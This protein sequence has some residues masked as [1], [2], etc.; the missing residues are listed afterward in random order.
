MQARFVQSL[1]LGRVSPELQGLLDSVMVVR[2]RKSSTAPENTQHNTT[3]N[4]TRR[5]DPSRQVPDPSRLDPLC[6]N[7]PRLIPPRPET[8]RLDTTLNPTTQLHTM[9]TR[10]DTT[11]PLPTTTPKHTP[12][13][14]FLPEKEAQKSTFK[15]HTN[16]VNK[17]T[18]KSRAANYKLWDKKLQE[19]VRD[20][21]ATEHEVPELEYSD[22]DVPDEN[23]LGSTRR[24]ISNTPEEDLDYP[25]PVHNDMRIHPDLQTYTSARSGRPTII[26]SVEHWEDRK[27]GLIKLEL[28]RLQ[29]RHVEMIEGGLIQGG[30]DNTSGDSDDA[31]GYSDDDA[32]E[33]SQETP[34]RHSTNDV[35][36]Q[37]QKRQKVSKKQNLI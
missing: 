32:P 22:N 1:R 24:R 7:T 11:H 13:R 17:A 21:Y 23:N 15:L 6:L 25:I 9:A 16:R 5:L 36:A 10:L 19:G 35:G 30:S 14:M 12:T 8:P 20:W 26:T 28:E 33:Y 2:G 31:S 18:L 3:Q 34:H 29:E 4:D 37:Q 27:E